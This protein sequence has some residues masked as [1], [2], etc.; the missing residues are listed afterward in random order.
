MVGGISDEDIVVFVDE[1]AVC[2]VGG[3]HAFAPSGEVFAI[4]VVDIERFF[5]ARIDKDAVLGVAGDAGD[6]AFVVGAVE[7]G[8]IAVVIVGVVSLAK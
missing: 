6:P 4:A 7:M 1:D 5:T 3:E 2:E 8:P